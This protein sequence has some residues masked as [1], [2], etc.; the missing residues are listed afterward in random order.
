[1]KNW[2]EK[3]LTLPEWDPVQ[4]IFGKRDAQ[5]A[6][7]QPV[8]LSPLDLKQRVMLNEHGDVVE[9]QQ[10]RRSTEEILSAISVDSLFTVLDSWSVLLG[11]P[12]SGKTSTM[13]WVLRQVANRN[14]KDFDHAI[15]LPL[16]D[17]VEHLS[18]HT[19]SNF[20]TF[21]FETCVGSFH[22]EAELLGQ[23]LKT[24]VESNP[25]SCLFLLDG[26]DEVSPSERRE[27]LRTLYH[28]LSQQRVIL[29]SRPSASAV[30]TVFQNLS[31]YEIVPLSPASI[32][33]LVLN[34]SIG[35]Q[36]NRSA[37]D[38]LRIL[39]NNI[40]LQQV[41]LTPFLLVIACEIL[42]RIEDVSSAQHVTQTWLFTKLVEFVQG[43]FNP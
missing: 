29:T 10:Q 27:L 6:L 9:Y 37:S 23:V 14:M 1:M 7:Y 16:A 33:R 38:I 25:H 19:N 8:Y 15:F 31:F 24:F 26:L 43:E 42:H 32:R 36:C 39:S 30:L 12:G 3:V 5:G 18:R 28:C 4:L 22:E 35:Y 11:I 17:L 13:K 34:F 2:Q 21:F 41:V 20:Y 40:S